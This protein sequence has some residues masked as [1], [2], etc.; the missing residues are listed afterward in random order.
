MAYRLTHLRVVVGGVFLGL[1][2][3]AAGFLLGC[4]EQAGGAGLGVGADL[5]GAVLRLEVPDERGGDRCCVF[6]QGLDAARGGLV[7]AADGGGVPGACLVRSHIHVSRVRG[8]RQPYF[9]RRLRA[10]QP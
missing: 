9:S 8:G 2:G 3:Q 10:I 5:V 4:Q 6:A 7:G 1:L